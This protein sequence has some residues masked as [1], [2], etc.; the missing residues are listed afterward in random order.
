[1]GSVGELSQNHFSDYEKV[2]LQMSRAFKPLMKEHWAVHCVCSINH[3]PRTASEDTL[4]TYK[5]LRNAWKRLAVEYPG[6]TVRPFEFTKHYVA[7]NEAVLEDWAR[8]TF[9]V[10]GEACADDIVADSE[11]RELPSFHYLPHAS[12]IVLLSQHW[13]TD[14]LGCCLLLNRFFELLESGNAESLAMKDISSLSPSLEVAAGASPKEDADIQAYAREHIDAFHAK[15]L[16]AGGLPFEGDATRPPARTKHHDLTFTISHTQR[17]VQACKDQ[18]MSVSAAIHVALARTYFSFAKTEEEKEAGYTTVMAVNMRPHLQVPYN[19]PTHACQTYVVSITPTVPYT[20][21]FP[22]AARALTYEYR[23]WYTEKF[24]RSL[25]WLFKYHAEKLFAPR[26]TPDPAKGQTADPAPPPLKPPSGV[27]L[28]SLGVVERHLE[29]R[30]GDRVTVERFRFGVSMMTRQ[31]LLY[32][33]TFR[34]ELTLSLDYNEAYY[35]HQMAV[36]VLSRAKKNLVEGLK[37]T[38]D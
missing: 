31:T 25:C 28:S 26:A 21:D 18:R 3:K 33:W 24:R 27:T 11:P 16:N 29:R 32:A 23:S 37:V 38:L 35:S 6:L 22:D 9:F 13:R 30:Y 5:A 15:A 7:L 34:G 36:E 17:I 2:Y 12:E 14:A 10:E 4:D 8:E 1:M 20:S 19:E